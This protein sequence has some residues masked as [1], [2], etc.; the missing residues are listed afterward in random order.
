MAAETVLAMTSELPLPQ[1]SHSPHSYSLPAKVDDTPRTAGLIFPHIIGILAFDT[2][3]LGIHPGVVA[4][5][6]E[7][8]YNTA[9]TALAQL[10]A[11]TGGLGSFWGASTA[12]TSASHSSSKTAP[13]IKSAPPPPPTSSSAPTTAD[14]PAAPWQRWSKLALYATAAT[15]TATAVGTA[16]YL[17][18][19]TLT[20]GLTW[21]SSHLE[22]IGCLARGDELQRRLQSILDLRHTSHNLRF[23]NLHTVLGAGAAAPGATIGRLITTG[24]RTFCSLPKPGSKRAAS[25]TGLVNDKAEDEVAAHMM[26]FYP[27]DNPGFYHMGELARDMVVEWLQGMT[28]PSTPQEDLVSEE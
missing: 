8:H 14:S 25:F 18:R 5:G 17:Q 23:T 1:P 15:A 9:S 7:G 21:A 22:F 2:P 12:T 4:H 3:Y 16:A 27:R 13:L 6:A 19:D 11:L 20:S 24:D 10:S 26:M 28:L